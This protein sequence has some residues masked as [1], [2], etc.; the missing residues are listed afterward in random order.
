MSD[1]GDRRRPPVSLAL[2]GSQK[3]EKRGSVGI[4]KAL[5]SAPCQLR[6]AGMSANRFFQSRGAIVQKRT[7][8]P[9]T[10]EGGRP[11]FVRLRCA[12]LDTIAGSDIMEQ[13]V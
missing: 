6:L 9:Q 3:G 10:P 7:A 12:L 11:D 8:Q 2:K 1:W 13:Q 4:T 5:E